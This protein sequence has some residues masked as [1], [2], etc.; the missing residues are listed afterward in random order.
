LGKLDEQLLRLNLDA[1]NVGVD[2]VA[3]PQ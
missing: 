2:D 1:R 3:I